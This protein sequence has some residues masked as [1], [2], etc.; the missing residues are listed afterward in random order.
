[1]FEKHWAAC[2][3][4][5]KGKLSKIFNTANIPDSIACISSLIDIV[6]AKVMAQCS[7][8]GGLKENNCLAAVIQA[9]TDKGVSEKLKSGQY[10]LYHR[11][12]GGEIG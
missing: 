5:R 1:M 6:Q 12:T 10:E 2:R 4:T 11:Q 7:E 8:D 9:R 3:C